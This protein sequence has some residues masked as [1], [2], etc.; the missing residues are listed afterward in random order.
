MRRWLLCPAVLLLGSCRSPEAAPGGTLEA[1]VTIESP[2][3]LR[4]REGDLAV[5]VL[6]IVNGTGRT[7]VLRD[8][9]PA[10]SRSAAGSAVMT[11]Q[12]SQP[13]LLEYSPE[14]DEWTYDRRRAA[15]KRR[16]VFNSGL[17]LPGES[18]TVRIRLRLLGLP[19]DLELV[20]YDLSRPDVT[21]MVYFEV[22][23]DRDVRFRRLVG[24]DL[25]RQMI[26]EIRSDRPGHRIVVFPYFEQVVPTTRRRAVRIEAAL[27]P[28]PFPLERAVHKAGFPCADE[29][30]Y[31]SGPGG[32]VLRRGNDFRLVTPDSVVPLPSLRQMERI[33]LLLDLTGA[34]PV[35]VEFL[36]ET[37]SLF[38]DRF[39]LVTDRQGRW[40][41]FLSP[42]EVL[43]FL[44]E[45][46]NAGL[47]VDADLTPEGR[48][49]LLVLRRA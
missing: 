3:S 23:E 10:G 28:L 41:A 33:F 21:Q 38:A 6:R 1:S 16:H 32:W 13:G 36:Q 42:P 24:E 39:R 12:C 37:K 15:D 47:S 8:L 30:T 49:Q 26:P 2:A 18:I 29:Y 5:A 9:V 4:P 20:Y 44:R 43:P 34:K 25:D 31:W 40:F 17:L 19:K 7:V 46:K 11:W 48:G 35:Q 14:R 22:R 45:V 27:E